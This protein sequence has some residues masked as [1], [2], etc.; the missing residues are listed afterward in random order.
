MTMSHFQT[1]LT[2][3]LLLPFP[4]LRF[5]PTPQQSVKQEASVTINPH[6]ATVHVRRD[7]VQPEPRIE[8]RKV[9]GQAKL[10]F[11]SDESLL[12]HMPDLLREKHT[13]FL[14]VHESMS[15]VDRGWLQPT[16]CN[17]GAPTGG[18]SVV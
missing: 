6:E 10:P 2:V 18:D 3:A 8:D 12:F 4:T 14:T 7:F 9:P 15:L 16:A 13:V 5:A 1:V 17:M 11:H